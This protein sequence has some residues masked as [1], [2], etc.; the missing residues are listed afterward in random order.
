MVIKSSNHDMTIQKQGIE[1][2]EQSL[3]LTDT[4]TVHGDVETSG[5]QDEKHEETRD[6]SYETSKL[7]HQ[8][9]AMVSIRWVR[10]RT[11]DPIHGNLRIV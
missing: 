9:N 1:S 3:Q 10:T 8:T 2:L 7:A 11:H 6:R 5:T 4:K